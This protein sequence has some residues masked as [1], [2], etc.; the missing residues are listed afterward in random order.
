[1]GAQPGGFGRDRHG[2]GN[3]N[4]ANAIGEYLG[5]GRHPYYL[6]RLQPLRESSKLDNR[7]VSGSRDGL[8]SVLSPSHQMMGAPYLPGFGRCGIPRTSPLTKPGA[9]DVEGSVSC[10]IR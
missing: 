9:T 6:V 7:R 4:A 2:G 10:K 1:L 5:S 8:I 3:L